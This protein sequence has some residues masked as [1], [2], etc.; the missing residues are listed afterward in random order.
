MTHL[1]TGNI[2]QEC[3]AGT[4]TAIRD[5]Q[6][7]VTRSNISGAIVREAESCG[8]FATKLIKIFWQA[9]SCIFAGHCEL[10]CGVESTEGGGGKEEMTHLPV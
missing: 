2:V 6:G 10:T 5:G 8:D 7:Q 4:S 9:G 1:N 3:I